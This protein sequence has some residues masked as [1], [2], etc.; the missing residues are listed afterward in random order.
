[1]ETENES[2]PLQRR[3]PIR[4]EECNIQVGSAVQSLQLR[5]I[6]PTSLILKLFRVVGDDDSF[7]DKGS[8]FGGLSDG[9]EDD[10]L[11]S[12]PSS[13]VY[14]VI[15]LALPFLRLSSLPLSS[16]NLPKRPRLRPFRVLPLPSPANLTFKIGRF[17]S[18]RSSGGR[19]EASP[20]C[21]EASE[22]FDGGCGDDVRL[23]SPSTR[24]SPEVL[25]QW[26]LEPEGLLARERDEPEPE[27][28]IRA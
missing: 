16:P 9:A 27:A 17:P 26:L 3:I 2:G 8:F 10:N 23:L 15:P 14:W 6:V 24:G 11:R 5:A 20:G 19:Y 28:S 22:V 18:S 4:S 25:G 21:S 12:S 13:S 7:S 1:M